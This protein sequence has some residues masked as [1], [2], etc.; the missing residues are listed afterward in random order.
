MST[1]PAGRVSRLGRG[2]R[3]IRFR[4][5]AALLLALLSMLVA[6]AYQIGEQQRVSESLAL[7]SDG[8]QPLLKIVA[9]LEQARQR[10]DKDVER[11]V[12]NKSRPSS[13]AASPTALYTDELASS[14]ARGREHAQ[15]AR[16][17]ARTPEEAAFLAKI[18]GQLATIDGLFQEWQQDSTMFVAMA[19]AGAVEEAR[20]EALIRKGTAL[21]DEI[22]KLGRDVDSRIAHLM[23]S[24]ELAQRRATRISALIT[25][26]AAMFSTGLM[27]AVLYALRPIGRLTTEVQRLAGG[28]YGGRV[29]VRGADEVAI[30]A[31]EFNAMARA[32]QLRDRTLVE[33]A[34]Q[35]DRLSRYLGSVLDRMEDGLL[36]VEDG[37]VAL[38]NPAAARTWGAADGALPPEP[39]RHALATQG[40]H[41]LERP[42]GTIHEVRVAPFGDGGA[43]LVSV[44]VTETTRTRER[45]A[46]SE[47][48][49]L[50]G[51]MLAQ[52]THEVRNPLNALSL[53][54]ELLA[55]ELASL[56]PERRSEAWELLG[57]VAVE[58]ER[59]TAVTGHYLQLARRPPATMGAE[60]VGAIV[61]DVRRLLDAELR[62]RGVRFEV[63]A[64]PLPAQL[65]DGNQLKQALL[66]VV[67]NAVEAGAR[68]IEL[69][70]EREGGEVRLRL[71]DDGPGMSPEEVRQVGEPFYTTKASGT[72]L[73]LAITKQILEAHDGAVRVS[74]APGQGT[75]VVLAFPERIA[76]ADL[77][78]TR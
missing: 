61:E 32:L 26:V 10:V 74:S 13:G 22:G 76:P 39:L 17:L 5:L 44:D 46:R 21:G 43:L 50:I 68:R 19:E 37:R 29:E 11:L 70:V 16:T 52:V 12:A 64:R 28:D 42:D 45:L 18:D 8:Y 27:V 15:H 30:L 58:I 4:I 47:R 33:R 9:R 38:T 54:A 59:L 24:T 23:R 75:T 56:D 72:G 73:G 6:Q 69:T 48:L 49:A 1:A 2:V 62:D 57:T 14:L 60:D 77:T 35:L 78:E 40:F 67:R 51:Q 63:R 3:T 65:V 20:A 71:R 66:N 25:A 55:D 36:V 7:V 34:E 53:N 31:A 41:V